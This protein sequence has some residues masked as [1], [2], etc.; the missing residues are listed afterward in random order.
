MATRRT[1][2]KSTKS[3]QVKVI[4]R[5]RPFLPGEVRKSCVEIKPK[6]CVDLLTRTKSNLQV[7]RFKFDNSYDE[8]VSQKEL[9]DSE[10]KP[11]LTNVF[12]GM[13]T[14]IFAYGMTGAG[15]TFTMQGVEDNPGIIP[16][17]SK[18]VLSNV[19]RR[20]RK[21]SR[22]RKGSAS[23][24]KVTVSYLEIYNEKVY[25]LLRPKE[26]D[27]PIREDR[28]RNIVIP[29]LAEVPI[30][31]HEQFLKTYELGCNNRTTAATKLNS[32]SNRSHAV[33]VMKITHKETV[34]PFRTL[35]GKLH[36]IDL[37][38]S[39][40]NRR[41][42]NTGVRMTESTNINSSLFVLGKVVNALNDGSARI[43][44]R[45]SKLTRLLQDSLGGKSHAIMIAN[46][47]PLTAYLFETNRTLNFASKSR[48]VTNKPIVHSSVDRVLLVNKDKERTSAKSN[49]RERSARS[50]GPAAA[51]C[52]RHRPSAAVAKALMQNERESKIE[53]M[54]AKQMREQGIT[55]ISEYLKKNKRMDKQKEEYFNRLSQL[56]KK[57]TTLQQTQ[58]GSLLET[59]YLEG[60]DEEEDAISF[61]QEANPSAYTPLSKTSHA[62]TVL[63]KAKK[64]E[65]SGQHDLAIRLYEKA[66][67]FI[68][69]PSITRKLRRKISKLADE[70]VTHGS[71][72]MEARAILSFNTA[73]SDARR[74]RKARDEGSDYTPSWDEE[75]DEE[76]EGEEFESMAV[77]DDGLMDPLGL[78]EQESEEEPKRK[79]RGSDG[80]K[81]KRIV[82]SKRQIVPQKGSRKPQG[83][84]RAVKRRKSPLSIEN[85]KNATS[86]GHS[87]RVASA[88]RK[89]RNGT[90][91]SSGKTS[92]NKNSPKPNNTAVKIATSPIADA[93]RL[94]SILSLL[95]SGAVADLT[96]LKTIGKKRAEQIVEARG[97]SMAYYASLHDL[98]HTGVF[99]QRQFDTFVEKNQLSL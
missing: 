62:H 30:D 34:S 17:I 35:T 71:D 4:V 73:S 12:D 50:G 91:K 98:V 11:H 68:D 45:D 23:N 36:L 21:E 33:M 92:I 72:G 8:K 70:L 22:H 82:S 93:A 40:D 19:A 38:G 88:K 51:A 5:L 65:K 46:I 2:S 16:R 32:S 96:G 64:A 83:S 9:F 58:M 69:D 74:R 60:S 27:L 18:E 42:G 81:R 55:L 14:T 29:Q 95:N 80:G 37:A 39:E 97:V 10:I 15:K 90:L 52:G 26:K 87:G 48:R 24:Y 43:P 54:I 6:G 89:K 63:I 1:S 76:E 61:S 59:E 57:F 41:T 75:E 28:D 7:S 66:L 49:G 85:K 78:L 56:E 94:K 44:Y 79:T 67:D 3:T 20:D 99:T 84:S 31:S 53:E 13:N 86:N 47:A 25:D 77:E